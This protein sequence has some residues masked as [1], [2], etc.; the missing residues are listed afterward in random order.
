MSSL[1]AHDPL[2]TLVQKPAVAGRPSGSLP[3]SNLLEEKVARLAGPG[4]APARRGAPHSTR[5]PGVFEQTNLLVC[6]VRLIFICIFILVSCTVGSK[7]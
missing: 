2:A 1:V 4:A 6:I 3:N 7:L 5:V